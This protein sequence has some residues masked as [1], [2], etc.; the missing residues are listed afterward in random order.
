MIEHIVCR[1]CHHE[2]DRVKDED[3]TAADICDWCGSSDSFVLDEGKSYVELWE[4]ILKSYNIT[5]R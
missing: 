5:R 4:K 1:D 3:R 2:W